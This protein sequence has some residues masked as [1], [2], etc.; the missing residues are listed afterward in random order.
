MNA[1]ISIMRDIVLP[2]ITLSVFFLSVSCSKLFGVHEEGLRHDVTFGV[3]FPV[4]KSVAMGHEA[5]ARSLDVLV[6]RSDGSLDASGRSTGPLDESGNV[7]SVTASVSSG[8][9]L[10]WYVVANAP[11][12]AFNGVST[13]TA[14]ESFVADLYEVSD[15]DG[16]LP[17]YRSGTLP[18]YGSVSD[19]VPVALQRHCCKVSLRNVT[20]SWAD[21]FSM[22]AEVRIGRI[23]LVNV[24]GT[25]LW[26]GGADP[27]PV[28]YNCM[29]ID[30]ESGSLAARMTV[31]HVDQPLSLSEAFDTE[32]S[33]YCMPNAV[34]NNVNSAN[35]GTWSERST[36]VAVEIIIGG[37][38]NWYAIDMPSML[39][40]THYVVNNL[41]V[42]GPGSAGP[43][44]PVLRE[45]IV[46]HLSVEPWLDEEVVP[47]FD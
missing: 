15:A 27:A 20:V 26:S 25:R 38:S 34:S 40:N 11:A 10:T 23:A 14:F 18:G 31:S 12:G 32:T 42:T 43:D 36:R 28:W 29:D 4:T 9:D 39:P 3:S 33:L 46:F 45:D 41:L 19:N 13:R 30:V 24:V 17:M 7:A 1:R 35:A 5:G 8:T 47:V 21:A 22:S 37:S 2:V 44:W 6:F 16:Y